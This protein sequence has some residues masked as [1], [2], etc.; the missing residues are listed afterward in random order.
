MV[1]AFLGLWI[2]NAKNDYIYACDGFIE[3]AA[4]NIGKVTALDLSYRAG[5]VATYAQGLT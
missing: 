3:K 2:F 4:V 1:A 5:P